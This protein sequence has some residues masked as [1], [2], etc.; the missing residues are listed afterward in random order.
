MSQILFSTLKSIKPYAKEA[1]EISGKTRVSKEN[2]TLFKAYM[3][4]VNKNRH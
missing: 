2:L 3:Q 4:H 1:N